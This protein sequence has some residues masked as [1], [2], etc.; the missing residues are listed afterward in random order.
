MGTRL[1]FVIEGSTLF[2]QRDC[3]NLNSPESAED[4]QNG[5]TTFPTNEV[6]VFKNGHV[7]HRKE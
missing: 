5:H 4:L 3:Q 2:Q 1:Y 7:K 6:Q